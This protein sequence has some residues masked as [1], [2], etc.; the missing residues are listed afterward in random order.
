MN[1]SSKIV[2]FL[3]CLVA[4][5]FFLGEMEEATVAKAVK[6]NVRLAKGKDFSLARSHVQ[7]RSTAER[8]SFSDHEQHPSK[9]FFL[10]S[11]DFSVHDQVFLSAYNPLW[12]ASPCQ[13]A[14]PHFSGR[15]PP[16]C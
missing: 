16:V 3:F 4:F 1:K 5:T 2:F 11:V 15:A 12:K 13:G 10:K 8:V 9:T 7:A 6:E 14:V